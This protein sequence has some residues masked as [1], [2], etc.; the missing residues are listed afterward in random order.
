V[1]GYYLDVSAAEL[2]KT[3]EVIEKSAE[4]KLANNKVGGT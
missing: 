1:S 2:T 3:A 4:L